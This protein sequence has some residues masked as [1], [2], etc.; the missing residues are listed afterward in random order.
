MCQVNLLVA[1]KKS[2]VLINPALPFS[3]PLNGVAEKANRY[4]LKKALALIFESKLPKT[5]W[6]CTVQ[7]AAYLKNRI[8][9]KTVGNVPYELKYDKLPYLN[10]IKVFGCDAYKNS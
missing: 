9:N 7:T 5:C 2:G 1:E 3:A 10:I 4:L 8:P 6:G